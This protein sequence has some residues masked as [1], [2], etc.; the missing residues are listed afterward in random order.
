MTDFSII[1]VFFVGLLGGVLWKRIQPMTRGC[2]P[3]IGACFVAWL[4]QGGHA[5]YL[6]GWSGSCNVAA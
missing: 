1:A 5:F 2:F 6:Y 3:L 4:V